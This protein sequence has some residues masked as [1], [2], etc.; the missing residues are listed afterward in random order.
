LSADVPLKQRVLAAAAATPSLTR[1][2]GRRRA[3]LLIAVSIAL[4][5]GLFEFLGGLDHSGQRTTA[6]AARLADGWALASAALTWLVADRGRSTLARSPYLLL[7]SAFACPVALFVWMQLFDGM[8]GDRSYGREMACLLYTLGAGI[9]PLL[10]FVA[11][12]RGVD[13]NHRS[14]LGA[15]GGAMCG[16]WSGLPTLLWCPLTDARHAI[17]GH[18]T[19]IVLLIGMGAVL[20]ILVLGISPVASAAPRCSPQWVSAARR[21]HR[22]QPPLTVTR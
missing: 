1:R 14:A 6:V 22:G 19:P 16:A 2:Q 3:V 4:G 8:A 7:A 9:T 15:A 13:P 12:R 20:G 5:V 17:V 18:V 21:R 11:L 10:S